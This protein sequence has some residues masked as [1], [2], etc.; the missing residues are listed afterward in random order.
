[1]SAER[2]LQV[3]LA[4]L[5][6]LGA[7]LLGMGQDAYG[8]TLLALVVAASSIL[9]TDITGWVR[10]NRP[11]ANLAALIAVALSL[12]D[13]FEIAGT[14][15]H[16]QL[17]A[18]ANLLVYLQIVLLYQEK[19]VRIYWQ[20]LAL[21]LLQVVVAAALSESLLFGFLVV[22]YAVLAIGAMTLIL[23]YS[24][25]KRHGNPPSGAAARSGI[26]LM[27]RRSAREKQ[28]GAPADRQR[29]PR[30]HPDSDVVGLPEE[31]V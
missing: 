27:N 29:Q 15:S 24:E 28:A 10:I 13:F 7:L 6:A 14:D 17:L 25:Q 20:L 22:L 9:V 12:S 26:D 23:L 31:G 11:I 4:T 21:S 30:R 19:T 3:L 1:M 16:T 5:V 2:L 8:L 18:I